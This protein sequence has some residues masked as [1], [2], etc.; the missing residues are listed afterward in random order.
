MLSSAYVAA[1]KARTPL[2]SVAQP[3]KTYL[4]TVALWPR[5]WLGPALVEVVLEVVLELVIEAEVEDVEDVEALDV[6]EVL[7]VLV[8]LVL[9]DVL[10]VLLDVCAAFEYSSSLFP[11]PQ[12]SVASPAHTILQSARGAEALV[13]S[14]ESP[15]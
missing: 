9:V 13:E 12:N 14:G 5:V 3:M 11:L 2:P 10:P 4:P 6:L 15:Q 7:E 8:R 1:D